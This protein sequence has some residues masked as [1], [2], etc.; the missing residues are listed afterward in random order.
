MFNFKE[1]LDKYLT[2]EPSDDGFSEWSENVVDNFSDE[3]F[4]KNE[5]WIMNNEM[6][7]RWMNNL[8]SNEYEPQEASKILERMFS[9]FIE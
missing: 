2:S 8:F 1:S 7:N 6:C 5:D 3:F 9:V 4:Q